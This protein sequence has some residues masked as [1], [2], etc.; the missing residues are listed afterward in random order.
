MNSDAV[1]FGCDEDGIKNPHVEE[2]IGLPTGVVG[3][4]LGERLGYEDHITETLNV[5][6]ALVDDC[7]VHPINAFNITSKYSFYEYLDF[8]YF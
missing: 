2:W 6:K 7:A 5:L 4:E 8:V 1:D 3:P